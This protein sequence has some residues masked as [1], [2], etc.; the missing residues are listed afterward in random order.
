MFFFSVTF[1]VR[2]AKAKEKKKKDLHDFF[3][4]SILTK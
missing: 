2:R 3:K 4:V 1:F